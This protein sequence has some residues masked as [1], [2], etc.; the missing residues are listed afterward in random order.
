[1]MDGVD[2]MS[3]SQHTIAGVLIASCLSAVGCDST[4]PPALPEA[5]YVEIIDVSSRSRGE[6]R[7]LRVEPLDDETAL[8]QELNDLAFQHFPNGTWVNFGPDSAYRQIVFF[9]RG[10]KIELMSWHPLYEQ[11]PDVV[12]GSG[13]LIP[14][15]GET[16]EA[17]LAHDDP[18]YVAQ[19]RVFDEIEAR[20]R[21]RYGSEPSD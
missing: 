3:N 12:A 16:R 15:E 19:R 13:G 17:F 8:L 9:S 14:L 18:A 7:I 6:D 21:Q 2:A 20:L 4:T 10:R 5:P 1:M 11:A